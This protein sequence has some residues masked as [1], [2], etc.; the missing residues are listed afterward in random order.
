MKDIIDFRDNLTW[1]NFW[2]FIEPEISM[3]HNTSTHD[4]LSILS[5]EF[6]ERIKAVFLLNNF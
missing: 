6:N 3:I 1:D 5:G 4:S 2:P